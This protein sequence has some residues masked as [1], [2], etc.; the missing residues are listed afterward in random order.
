MKPATGIYATIGVDAVN[1]AIDSLMH[2]N[3]ERALSGR[4]RR[5]CEWTDGDAGQIG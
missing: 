1:K 5:R 4:Y 3:L 2:A